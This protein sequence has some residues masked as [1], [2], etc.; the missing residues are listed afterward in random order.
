MM[1]NEN[2]LLGRW[3]TLVTVEIKTPLYE[4]DY[5]I[6]VAPVSCVDA[7]CP[8]ASILRFPVVGTSAQ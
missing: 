7:S 5:E 6:S 2:I 4:G 8:Q 3:D 1:V